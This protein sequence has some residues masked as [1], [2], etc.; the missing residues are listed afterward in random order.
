MLSFILSL[1]LIT[2]V[3]LQVANFA[4]FSPDQTVV[5]LDNGLVDDHHRPANHNSVSV[6]I[7]IAPLTISSDPTPHS[8]TTAQHNFTGEPPN[9]P[10]QISTTTPKPTTIDPNVDPEDSI[11]TSTPGLVTMQPPLAG[12]PPNKETPDK[13]ASNK[14]KPSAS[15]QANSAINGNRSSPDLNVLF[16]S[17]FIVYVSFIKLIYHN[18]TFIKRNMTEPG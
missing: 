9:V 8:A 18:V 3:C 10:N 11:A 15:D 17:I 12:W 16:Y 5:S 7:T 13:I 14:T 4:S 1:F 2:L 6:A